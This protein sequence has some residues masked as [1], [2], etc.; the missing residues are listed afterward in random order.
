MR[1]S[2]Q[3]P[4]PT[5]LKILRG[6]PGHQ[7]IDPRE[8]KIPTA[9]LSE[10]TDLL[11]ENG[12]KEWRRLL[13]ILF[14]AGLATAADRAGLIGYCDLWSRWI[15]LGR[16]L[17]SE[18]TVVTRKGIPAPSRYLG[19]YLEVFKQLRGCMAEFGLTPASRTRITVNVPEPK[20]KVDSF[21]E[22]HG[23]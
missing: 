4:V 13:P 11:D 21:R 10:P 22:K 23:G 16:R 15:E 17:R 6:N 18:G 14:P 9:D 5:A 19:A 2:G 3:Q 20:S 1:R 12:L 7:R 8:P